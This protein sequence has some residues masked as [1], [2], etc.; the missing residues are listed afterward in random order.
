MIAED[1]VYRIGIIGKPHGV[2]GEVTFRFDDDAFDRAD[3]DFLILKIDG[4]L[5]PFYMEEYRFRSNE[6][7]LV[8]FEDIDTQEQASQ[9]TGTEVFLPRELADGD[10][11]Q[12]SLAQTVG[13]TIRHS[14]D[15]KSIG[16]IASVDTSTAN[17]LFELEDGKLIPIAEE[18]ITDIDKQSRT[19]AMTLPEGLLDL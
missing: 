18:W 7:A 14:S 8:K 12:M 19:I 1:K 9:L 11:S 17:I 6:T 2:K 3:A 4:I 16:R 5:V 13:F 10:S 15:G